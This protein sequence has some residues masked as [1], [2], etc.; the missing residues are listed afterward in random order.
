MTHPHRRFLQ[1]AA[2]AVTLPA[3]FAI[4]IGLTGQSAW[5]QTT[6]TIKVVVPYPP[7]GNA[8]IL[9]RLLA[10]QVGRAQG[11]TMVIENRP[12]AGTVIGTEAVARATPDGNTLMVTGNSSFLI[13]PH[14]RKVNYD[15]LSSFEPICY[16]ASVPTAIVVNSTS[17]YRT[18]A[19]LLAAARDKPRVMTLA[20]TGPGTASQI[21]F[22]MLKRAANVDMTFVPYP[23][24]APAITALLGD[25]VHAVL[26]DYAVFAGPVVNRSRTPNGVGNSTQL[27]GDYTN[28]ILKPQA[29]ETV[30]KHGEISLTGVAYPTPANQCWPQ[31]VPYI[32]WNLGM[33]MLQQ[34]HQITFLYDKDHEVRHVRMNVPHPANVTPSWYGDS[35]GHYEGDTLVIDTIGIKSD[36]PHAMADVYGTP[37]TKALHVVE[38]YRLLDYESTIEAQKRGFKENLFLPVNDSGLSVAP[39]DRSKGL[40]LQFTVEDDGVFTMPWSAAIVYRRAS[41]EWPEYICSDNRHEYYAG[42]ET[43]VP[44][45]ATPDF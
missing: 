17:P 15:P 25:H 36:R 37:Y 8:D 42:K 9:T 13:N 35:V 40:Y 21:A 23:G 1:L 12:G 2:G 5:S 39:N 41:G 14:L 28:P 22:E 44:Q 18:L 19:E 34:P 10:E 20:S 43:A 7:G 24:Y 3:F 45:A 27:V 29:A 33:Q 38:R 4:M 32:F 31:P 30:K 11:L 26:A 16:L 6:K